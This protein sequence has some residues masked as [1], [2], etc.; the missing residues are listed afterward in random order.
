MYH[1]LGDESLSSAPE[2][3]VL[4]TQVGC[5]PTQ[6]ALLTLM[7]AFLWYVLADNSEGGGQWPMVR[8]KA[9]AQIPSVKFLTTELDLAST[10]S[11]TCRCFPAF[12]HGSGILPRF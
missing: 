9:C 5:I 12:S 10:I 7:N 2:Q 8:D 11:Y 3:C 6:E 1:F 4:G